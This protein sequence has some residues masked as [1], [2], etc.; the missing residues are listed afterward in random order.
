MDMEVKQMKHDPRKLPDQET[1]IFSTLGSFV[2]QLLMI[3]HLDD[4]GQGQSTTAPTS[5]QTLRTMTFPGKFSIG[6]KTG[7]KSFRSI[8]MSH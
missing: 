4:T 6:Q 2:P 1:W 5:V 8:H 7:D 3:L